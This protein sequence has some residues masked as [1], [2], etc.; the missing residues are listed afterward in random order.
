MTTHPPPQPFSKYTEKH[1][2]GDIQRYIAC[3]EN[4]RIL[5]FFR[6]YIGA[7]VCPALSLNEAHK[8]MVIL[9][10]HISLVVKLRVVRFND[11]LNLLTELSK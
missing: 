10:N 2:E 6:R 5:L 8:D 4:I 7:D 3:T 11:P 1:G 9:K